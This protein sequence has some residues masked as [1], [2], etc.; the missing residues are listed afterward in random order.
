MRDDLSSQFLSTELALVKDVLT[1]LGLKGVI[2]GL[3]WRCF[4]GTGVHANLRVYLRVYHIFVF[5]EGV[6]SA[7]TTF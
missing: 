7:Y 5:S 2:M 3:L 1:A 6:P 4:S